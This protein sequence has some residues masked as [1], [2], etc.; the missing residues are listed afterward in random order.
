MKQLK[1]WM[2]VTTLTQNLL[3][4]MRPNRLYRRLVVILYPQFIA[5]IEVLMVIVIIE[6][7]KSHAPIH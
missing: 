7:N 4:A 2:L 3:F 1:L 5:N 6:R